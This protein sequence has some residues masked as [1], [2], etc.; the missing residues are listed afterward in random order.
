MRMFG[1]EATSYETSRRLLS[2]WRYYWKLQIVVLETTQSI[3]KPPN[4]QVN[5][6][7]PVVDFCVKK[8]HI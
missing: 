3:G 2:S 7:I 4:S 8:Y 6:K 1:I 5:F